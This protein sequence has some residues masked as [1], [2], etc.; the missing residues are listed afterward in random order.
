MSGTSLVTVMAR[1]GMEFG[2]RL[3]GTGDR[4]FTAPAPEV[5]GLYL[6]GF[7][8]AYANPDIGD[9]AITETVNLGGMAMAA[10]PAIVGFVGETAAGAVRRTLRGLAA[11]S[12]VPLAPPA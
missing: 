12:P 3:S 5:H 8:A 2:M 9:S 7:S 1:N 10:A 11:P 4:W 6:P